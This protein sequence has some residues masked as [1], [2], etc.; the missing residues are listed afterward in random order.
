[1][2]LYPLK[3][4]ASTSFIQRWA[5]LMWMTPGDYWWN[6]EKWLK[7]RADAERFYAIAR[8]RIGLTD[9]DYAHG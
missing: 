2:D 4:T 8:S 7:Q 5:A 9:S 6:P 3:E 1:M